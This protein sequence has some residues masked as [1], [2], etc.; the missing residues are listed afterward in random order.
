MRVSLPLLGF[1]LLGSTAFARADVIYNLTLTSTDGY[2]GGTGSF[3]LNTPP[4]AIGVATYVPFYVPLYVPCTCGPDTPG[5]LLL[6]F[7][8][9]ISV[10]GGNASMTLDY[11]QGGVVFPY[12][13]FTDG[14]PS[15]FSGFETIVGGRNYYEFGVGVSGYDFVSSMQSSGPPTYRYDAGTVTIT[16]AAVAATPEPSSLALVGT[17]L[18]GMAA[19]LTRR[20]RLPFLQR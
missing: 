6:A 18:L 4:P 2:A 1:V 11:F 12:I 13:Q 9:S 19:V 3:T 16:P 20:I 8:A 17:G 5:G 10:A 15:N 14:V 7:N